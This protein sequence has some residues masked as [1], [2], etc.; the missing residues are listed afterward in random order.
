MTLIL[1]YVITF[2][3]SQVRTSTDRIK[4]ILFGASRFLKQAPMIPMQR[5]RKG[6]FPVV[7]PRKRFYQLLRSC[8]T[9][10]G[11]WNVE[12]WI[13]CRLVFLKSYAYPAFCHQKDLSKRYRLFKTNQ[14]HFHKI[15]YNSATKPCQFQVKSNPMSPN[16]LNSLEMVESK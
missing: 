7:F 6:V 1:L 15:R 3:P 10:G 8:T 9:T 14:A 16:F 2:C 13:V 4:D 12:L 11:E 5:Q